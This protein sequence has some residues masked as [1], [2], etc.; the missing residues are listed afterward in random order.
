M[1]PAADW[2]CRPYTDLRA[3]YICTPAA[4][5]VGPAVGW[6]LTMGWV[7]AARRRLGRERAAC[8]LRGVAE[9]AKL[10]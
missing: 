9:S 8:G 1:G 4:V 3:G 10:V 2:E 7:Q 5:Q 6:Q